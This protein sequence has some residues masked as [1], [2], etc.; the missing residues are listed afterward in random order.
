MK[1]TT[2]ESRLEGRYQKFREMG[3]LGRDFGVDAAY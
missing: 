3:R 2:S 1:A